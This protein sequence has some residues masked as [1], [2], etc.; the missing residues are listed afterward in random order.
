MGTEKP[1]SEVRKYEHKAFI[2]TLV[3]KGIDGV[4]EIIG[5]ILLL[6]ISP[7]KMNEY[8]VL[9]T[10]HELSRNPDDRLANY[11]LNL[12]HNIS[13][14]TTIF[15]GL[16]LL[17]HGV[18]KVFIVISLLQKKL[19]AYPVGIAFFSAFCIYQ[20][21]RFAITH[22]MSM[23]FLTVLDLIVIWLTWKEYKR[24]KT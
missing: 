3:I 12:S 22:S 21:Y 19:W 14:D 6:V 17:S 20:I 9:L 11:L 24:L 23:V 5:G 10:Q 8:V 7:A 13:R 2:L 15:A 1:K 16:Y 4:L 18:V